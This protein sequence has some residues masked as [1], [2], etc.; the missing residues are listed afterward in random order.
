LIESTISNLRPDG[1]ILRYDERGATTWDGDLRGSSTFSGGGTYDPTTGA[2]VSH[3][4]EEFRGL[5]HGLGV[6]RIEWDT[7]TT[8]VLGGPLPASLTMTV[9][10]HTSGGDVT[11]QW[12]STVSD[13]GHQEPTRTTD[14]LGAVDGALAV[15]P[16]PLVH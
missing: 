8:G 11:G 14:V 7:D 6:G 1:A 10:G 5:V 12:V 15:R 16:A 3:L 2:F 13:P 9:R 4:H